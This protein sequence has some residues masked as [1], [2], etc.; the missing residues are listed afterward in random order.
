M[1]LGMVAA[2]RKKRKDFTESILDSHDRGSSSSEVARTFA[3]GGNTSVTSLDPFPVS[4]PTYNYVPKEMQRRG[5]VPNR[6]SDLWLDRELSGTKYGIGKSVQLYYDTARLKQTPPP[7]YQQQQQQDEPEQL[8]APLRLH[9]KERSLPLDIPTDIGTGF[10]P[11]SL[12]PSSESSRLSARLDSV[13]YDIPF[14]TTGIKPSPLSI[15]E[16]QGADG[17]RTSRSVSRDRRRQQAPP[18]PPA[19]ILGDAPW[20]DDGSWVDIGVV[21]DE[22]RVLRVSHFSLLLRLFSCG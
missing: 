18:P 15:Y 12:R 6:I 17:T 4:V 16:G 3:L 1:M 21:V 8:T 10:V 19:R 22:E 2:R 13:V 20:R 5:S 7:Q 14:A 11:P 9:R